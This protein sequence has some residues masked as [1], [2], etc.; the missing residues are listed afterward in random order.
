MAMHLEIVTAEGTKLSEEV[1]EITAP[2]LMGEL[3]ILENHIPVL[4]VLDTGALTVKTGKG[5]QQLAV[6]GGFLEVDKNRL[7]IITETAE[8]K[9]EI[10]VPRAQAS[11]DRAKQSL[12]GLETGS[13]DYQSRIRKVRR[14]ENRLSVA[15]S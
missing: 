15:N 11:I 12:A 7:I 3:G 2:G 5:L 1:T 13:A 8:L 14:N 6:S 10:D 4:T 9:D